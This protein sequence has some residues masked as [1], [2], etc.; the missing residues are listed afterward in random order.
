MKSG[1]LR[2]SGI[3]RI[4]SKPEFSSFLMLVIML[5][6]TAVLQKNFFETK[7]IM[8]NINAFAPLILV[9][10]GQA[11]VIL[12]GGLDL[13]SGSALS[14][15]TCVLTFVMKKNDP[16]SGV[17]AIIIAF[18]VA[19]LLGV[20]NGFGTGYLRIP[21]VIA[22]FATSFIWLGIALFLRPTPGGESVWWFGVFYDFNALKD[23]SG[24]FGTVG[25]FLPPAL[26]LI[27]AG[28]L[29]WFMVSKTRTGRYIYAVGGNNDSAYESGIK[30]AKVQILAYVINSMY[31]FL[32]ALFFV[33]QTG[34]GDARMG[35]PLT[36]RSIA[37]AVVGGVALAGG[38]GNVY[39]ALV[40]ALILSLVNKIIFFADIPYAYQ[41]L[42]GGA[43]VIIAIAGSQAYI[44]AST[45]T[46]EIK[47]G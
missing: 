43:I 27:L 7:S 17:Y 33:G 14:L 1:K 31:I 13:S 8:R 39:F 4:T 20:I 30:T 12:S 22:T 15:L 2:G 45:R 42:V 18:L 47:I 44:T 19:I 24:F 25:A 34:S 32:A 21:P 46:K 16:A 6:L 41:T 26:V 40:G 35:D 37:A 11:V 9:A 10:M 5:V 3:R 36:L 28:C 23:V 29:L 38:R